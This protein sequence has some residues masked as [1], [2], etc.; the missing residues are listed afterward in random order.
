MNKKKWI[1]ENYIKKDGTEPVEEFL[2]SL[3]HKDEIK[4]LRCIEL[5]EDLG[6]NLPGPHKESLGDGLLELRAKF[7]T[8]ITRIIYFHYENGRFILLHGFT[9]K[10]QKTPAS[11]IERAKRYREDFLQRNKGLN[12]GGKR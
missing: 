1:V 8:N 12:K 4:M 9:K 10:D 5:L 7:S 6:I 2:D 3:N 11:E